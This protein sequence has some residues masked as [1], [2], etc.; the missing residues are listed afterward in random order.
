MAGKRSGCVDTSLEDGRSA[1]MTRLREKAT[2]SNKS[3]A[4]I[5]QRLISGI[6]VSI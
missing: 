2:F 5:A 6:V 1:L 4:R 3:T